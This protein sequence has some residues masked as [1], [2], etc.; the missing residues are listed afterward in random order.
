MPTL[1]GGPLEITL[2]VPLSFD[3]KSR[4]LFLI[5]IHYKKKPFRALLY[6]SKWKDWFKK[7]SFNKKKLLENL[8]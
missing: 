2:T 7:F 4:N 3:C 1:Q 5:Y 6:C 8:L